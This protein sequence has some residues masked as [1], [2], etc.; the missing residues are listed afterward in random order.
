MK[1]IV[2]N[3]VNGN[4]G[5]LVAEYIQSFI[6]KD[7]LV[8]TCPNQNDLAEYKKK[9]FN[10]E[11]ADFNDTEKLADTFKNA[12]KVLLISLPFV[13]KKRREAH[14]NAIDACVKANVKQIVYTSVISAANPLNPSVE[15][16]DHAYTEAYIQNTS[17]D[18][19]FLRNTLFAEAFVTDYDRAVNNGEKSIKKNMGEGRVAF[20]SRKDAAFAA[21]CALNSDLLHRS[22]L[23]INGAE[24]VSYEQFLEIGNQ[25]TGNNI[26]Y[27]RQT[28][29]ELY[30]YF[31]SIGVPRDTSE[32]FTNSP[33]QATSE[34]MVSFGTA[35]AENYLDVSV[36]D[37]PKLT[38][39]QPI[40][41]E[42]MFKDKDKFQLGERHVAE[43]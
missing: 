27:I 35:V 37:F 22:I 16:I 7:N 11:L 33:I 41:L 36:N 8:F 19:I 10:T 39:R 13:G 4:F 14:K 28:D 21:T 32:D 1:K 34:G 17:L 2:V 29:E 6:P 26:E 24:L 30:E 38:G 9:G 25:V 5:S 23:N 31:D 15:N 12:D 20:I 42:E 3:G 18:Y 40:T 43:E